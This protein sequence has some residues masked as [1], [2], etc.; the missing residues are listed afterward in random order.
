MAKATSPE[1]PE[2]DR[3]TNQIH[4]YMTDKEMEELKR[5]AEQAHLGLSAYA[6]F[7]IFRPD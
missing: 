4:V 2:K 7:K 1:P 3:A 5:L 6:K